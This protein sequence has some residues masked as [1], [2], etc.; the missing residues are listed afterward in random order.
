MLFIPAQITAEEKKMNQQVVLLHG[1]ARSKGSLGKMEKRL[2]DCGY[3][4]CNISYPSTKYSIDKLVF[5]YIIPDIEK[6]IKNSDKTVNFVTHSMGGI[7]VRC[8]AKRKLNFNIGR[9]VMLSPPNKGSEVVDKLGDMWLFNLMNGPAGKEL[10]TGENSIPNILGPASFEVGII[11]G[12]KSIN[13]ILSTMISGKN[14]GKVSVERARLEGMAD[15]IVIPATHP[16]I[17][18]NETAIEQ[19]LFFLKHGKFKHD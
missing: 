3:N 8:L 5:D 9:V 15:F 6:C 16:F 12:D 14:D 7:I 18:K 19:T 11:T 17:M 2:Q 1:L 13:W 10:G 4:T